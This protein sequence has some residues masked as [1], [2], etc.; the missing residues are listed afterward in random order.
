MI[1]PPDTG[2]SQ[3]RLVF[4]EN[5]NRPVLCVYGSFPAPWQDYGLMYIGNLNDT[6]SLWRHTKKIL[7]LTGAAVRGKSGKRGKRGRKR[8]NKK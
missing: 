1:F 2:Y 8:R 7:F 5:K 6:I 3:E 4:M